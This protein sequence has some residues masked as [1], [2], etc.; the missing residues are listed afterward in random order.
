MLFALSMG[1]VLLFFKYREFNGYLL[2]F[3]GSISAFIEYKEATNMEPQIVLS[4]KGISTVKTG[5]KTWKDIRNETVEVHTGKGN[6][7]SYDYQ[8]GKGYLRI[9]D[10]NIEKW[11]LETLLKLYRDR[12]SA[13]NQTYMAQK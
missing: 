6:Y 7:L 1:I 2:L 10:F 12:Y 13:S 9:D 8:E 5:F 11:Q 4:N 3:L